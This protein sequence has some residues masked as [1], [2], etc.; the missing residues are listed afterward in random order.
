MADEAVK[1]IRQNKDRPFYVNVW[2]HESHTPH[3]PSQAAL[4][5]QHGLDEQ[6]RVYAAVIA[7]GDRKVGQ[8]LNTLRELELDDKTIVIFS[9][10]NG[11]EWTGPEAH[12]QLQ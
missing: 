8:V 9:S 3:Y 6:H 7:D 4:D 2:L 10:D 1:F 11:P 5:A 12:K